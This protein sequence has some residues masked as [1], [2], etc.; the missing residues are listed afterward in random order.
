M[1]K[2]YRFHG[3]AALNTEA[4]TVYLPGPDAARLAKAL[5]AVAR[6]IAKGE[7]FGDSKCNGPDVADFAHAPDGHNAADA[8][9]RGLIRVRETSP[10]HWRASYRT[11]PGGRWQ[12]VKSAAGPIDYTSP[13]TAYQA[14]LYT[15]G[16]FA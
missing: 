9:A 4:G 8:L 7:S 1:A 14:A 5:A 2:A 12:H 6:S 11:A 16:R 13:R 15:R 10:G 3:L